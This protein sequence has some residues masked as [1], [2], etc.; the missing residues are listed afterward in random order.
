MHSAMTVGDTT[1]MLSDGMSAE[2][3][4]FAGVTCQSLP[5]TKRRPSA[6]LTR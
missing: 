6:C 5:M 2:A 3:V 1:V 4:S